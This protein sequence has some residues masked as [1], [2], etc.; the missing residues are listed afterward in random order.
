[1]P[2]RSKL[3]IHAVV[4][5]LLVLGL[6]VGSYLSLSAASR[7]AE[8]ARQELEKLALVETLKEYCVF[9][10]P[11]PD[12]VACG[13]A[14]HALSSLSDREWSDRQRPHLERILAL[15][16]NIEEG[17]PPD[18]LPALRKA[19]SSF[20]KSVLDEVEREIRRAEKPAH[21]RAVRLLIAA[22][23][24]ALGGSATFAWLFARLVRERRD[25]EARVR[26][27][28]KLAA[29][30][31]LAAGLAHEINN[32]LATIAIS[33]E[34]LG[35]RV[36]D[37]SEEGEFCRAIQE[38]ADRC[39]AI[40]D[41]LTDLARSGAVD[42]E[43]VDVVEL[44]D[45]AL[46]II[47][48]GR[49]PETI[50]IRSDVPDDLPLLSADRGKLLQ[51]LVNLIANGI[52]AAGDEGE[53]R[54]S[55]SRSNSRLLIQVRDNGRGIEPARLDRIFEPFYTEKE[56][57]VGL[58]LTLCHR[59]AELHGGSLTAKSPGPGRGAVFTLDLPLEGGEHAG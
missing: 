43:P 48:R 52:E 46:R 13:R 9:L 40:I 18:E 25:L 51:V 31:T 5:A 49:P 35:A 10:G 12:P 14:R 56:R 41:D 28:E 3:I 8:D 16:K 6:A 22:V 15:S 26:R 17:V 1:M 7:E 20:E 21:R 24:V 19:V 59:I 50:S 29:L 30:G 58:G 57:G 42:R 4:M 45:E 23:L 54:L 36:P 33:A 47:R 53:V 2:L 38:E 32:P 39:R 44:A 37:G 34:V 27:S 55:A 11:V